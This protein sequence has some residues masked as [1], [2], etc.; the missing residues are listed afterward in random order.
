MIE[1]SKEILDKLR[2]I[3]KERKEEIESG[4]VKECEMTVDEFLEHMRKLTYD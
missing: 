1:I 4:K 2:K 3:T